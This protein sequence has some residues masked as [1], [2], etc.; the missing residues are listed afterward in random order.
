MKLSYLGS[1]FF[2][3]ATLVLSKNLD[4]HQK[5]LQRRTGGARINFMEVTINERVKIIFTATDFESRKVVPA[6]A[7]EVFSAHISKPYN[8]HERCFFRAS[9]Q[10]PNDQF[11]SPVFP[12]PEIDVELPSFFG[13]PTGN[14]DR[15]T[16]QLQLS[17]EETP[18]I[19]EY[20][21]CFQY[22]RRTGQVVV[23]LEGASDLP[24]LERVRLQSPR[25]ST[26]SNRLGSVARRD[27]RRWQI[28]RGPGF[29]PAQV[30]KAA[31]VMAPAMER[32]VCYLV[33]D[34]Q[35][36]HPFTPQSPLLTA[37][38]GVAEIVCEE[39]DRR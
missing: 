12:P 29:F 21:Y 14:I 6:D 2:A 17:P 28:F 33:A 13:N 34:E 36:I 31:I 35:S 9:E 5:D 4:L 15:E 8:G 38:N 19:A 16:Q 27:R 20:L 3:L 7:R 37:V 32:T 26:E 23:C 10:N 25:S 39:R 11:L 1:T 22:R 18:F 24:N 30:D